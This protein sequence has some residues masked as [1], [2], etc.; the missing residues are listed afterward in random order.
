[1]SLHE[2]INQ[3]LVAALKEKNEERLSTLRFLNSAIKN[4]I[5]AERLDRN[6]ALS[7]DGVMKIIKMQV[8]QLKEAMAEFKAGGRDDLVEKNQKE[9]DILSVYLPE[10]MGE[11][12]LKKII[13]N[14]IMEAGEVTAADFGRIM[15]AVMKETGGRA[16]GG[17]VKRLVEEEIAK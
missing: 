17:T 10:E 11:E 1:M 12:E 5:I 4:A 15:S 3:D 13:K 8:K 9:I 16:D 14:K 7:D 2:K 6:A